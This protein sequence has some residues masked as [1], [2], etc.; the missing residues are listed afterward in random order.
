MRA[1]AA[2]YQDLSSACHKPD[3]TGVANLFPNLAASNSVASREPTS[4]IRVVLRGTQ[5][6][7][8]PSAPT[9]PT[10]PA[11]GWQLSDA[12]VAAVLTYIRNSWGHAAAAVTEHNVRNARARLT[13]RND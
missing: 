3:G 2:I 11:Y 13:A 10:M 9:G 5:S 1:G 4:L 6:V 7:S 8:T 12:E